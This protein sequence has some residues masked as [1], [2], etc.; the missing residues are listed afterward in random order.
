LFALFLVLI[1]GSIMVGVVWQ[2]H[3][4]LEGGSLIQVSA[5]ALT[6]ALEKAFAM[7]IALLIISSLMLLIAASLNSVAVF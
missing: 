7:G 5:A 2:T 4:V 1:R 3:P 6:I